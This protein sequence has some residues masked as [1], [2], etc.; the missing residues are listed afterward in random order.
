MVFN[1]DGRWR[2]GARIDHFNGDHRSRGNDRTGVWGRPAVEGETET[3]LIFCLWKIKS[4]WGMQ[5]GEISHRVI[6]WVVGIISGTGPSQRNFITCQCRSER[7]RIIDHPPQSTSRNTP[8]GQKIKTTEPQFFLTNTC[9]FFISNACLVT[10]TP[11]ERGECQ[12]ALISFSHPTISPPYLTGTNQ[13]WS[14]SD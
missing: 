7:K 4:A 2:W 11:C 9:L 14:I 13:D 3:S 1:H 8:I 5:D 12:E 10:N 6:E